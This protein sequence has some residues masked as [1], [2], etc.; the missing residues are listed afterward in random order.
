VSGNLFRRLLYFT[1]TTQTYLVFSEEQGPDGRG[2]ARLG[3][4]QQCV[5]LLFD[6][7][8][9]YYILLGNGQSV[10]FQLLLKCHTHGPMEERE[11]KSRNPLIK[12][13]AGGILIFKIISLKAITTSPVF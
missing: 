3:I 4:E 5:C 11:R 7:S 9:H 10:V 8:L 13:R 6:F 12:S 1:I 2:P